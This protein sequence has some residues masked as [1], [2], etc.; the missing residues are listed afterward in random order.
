MRLRMLAA[1]AITAVSVSA[2]LAMTMSA[3]AATNGTV[4]AKPA[5]ATA[6]AVT[7]SAVIEQTTTTP[8]GTI[9]AEVVP[10]A[11][12]RGSHGC[13]GTFTWDNVK[14]CVTL[15]GSGLLLTKFEGKTIVK[16]SPIVARGVLDGP[17]F[18]GYTRYYH[19]RPGEELIY[20]V[21]WKHPHKVLPGQYCAE[22][23]GYHAHNYG[24]AC[25][26]V[27]A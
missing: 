13:V 12:I 25:E 5:A 2:A 3:N 23:Q 21:S 16:N 19:L 18:Y 11:T 7:A 20:Y 14:T 15:K 17:S 22:T 1:T 6:S 27:E 24:R 26:S 8:D 4:Q 9:T 10:A